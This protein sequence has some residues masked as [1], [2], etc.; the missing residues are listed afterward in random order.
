MNTR[1]QFTFITC[2]WAAGFAL[3]M[4]FTLGV[5]QIDPLF[6]GVGSFM[7]MVTGLFAGLPLLPGHFG[8][9]SV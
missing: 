9:R 5:G 7:A 1:R 2:C 3:A 4:A 6:W 8:G